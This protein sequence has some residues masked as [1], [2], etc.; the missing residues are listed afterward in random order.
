MAG[1]DIRVTTRRMRPL[2]SPSL[3]QNEPAARRGC[4]SPSL[5]THDVNPN[6]VFRPVESIHHAAHT[7]RGSPSLADL[8]PS[9]AN[10]RNGSPS[11][12][13]LA[14]SAL[15]RTHAPDARRASAPK[16]VAM[17]T[18]VCKRASRMARP[19]EPSAE[20]LEEA[21][22]IVSARE[23]QLRNR[24]LERRASISGIERWKLSGASTGK[25]PAVKAGTDGTDGDGAAQAK[26]NH[27][28]SIKSRD[29]NWANQEPTWLIDIQSSC[30]QMYAKLAAS[31]IKS[32]AVNSSVTDRKKT[33]GAA[34]QVRPTLHTPCF[35]HPT[36][37][38]AQW[39]V[40]KHTGERGCQ[41]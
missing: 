7:P 40:R 35:L 6:R 38:S 29:V 26:M 12:G 34:N 4:E 10:S 32:N 11:L 23:T 36:H 21:H 2:V 17:T 41:R 20:A 27:M 15:V 24:G 19:A 5:R 31:A 16:N 1:V 30:P 8:Q 14:P 37:A 22:R 39:T 28:V 18:A 33:Q 13:L 3:L 9:P 25:G